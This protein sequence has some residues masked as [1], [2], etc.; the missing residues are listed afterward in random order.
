MQDIGIYKI[1]NLI[2]NKV[3]IGQSE[4]LPK[5]WKNHLNSYKRYLK[6]SKNRGHTILWKAFDKYGLN[7]FKFTVV[8][9]CPKEYLNKLE[10]K[11]ISIYDSY[12]KGY[13]ATIGGQ[14]GG[15]MPKKVYQFDLKGNFLKEWTSVSNIV[16]ILKFSAAGIYSNINDKTFSSNG[17]LWSYSKKNV[18]EKVIRYEE[19][20]KRVLKIKTDRKGKKCPNLWQPVYMFDKDGLFIKK[21][22]SRFHLIEYLKETSPNISLYIKR[23]FSAK[24]ELIF[25][26]DINF[27]KQLIKKL[28]DCYF[29]KMSF[30]PVYQVSFEGEVLNKFEKKSEATLKLNIDDS[31][32]SKAL[33]GDR[34]SAGG[35]LWVRD[36]KEIKARLEYF[37][38]RENRMVNNWNQSKLLTFKE[39]IEK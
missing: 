16:K 5:R 28:K 24:H 35:F 25:S 11:F 36:L 13:N 10:V 17:F 34:A 14:C 7:N 31:S 39:F 9:N 32:I 30:K 3:Y 20:L 19:S 6:G 37:K 1:E 18:K 27:D 4:N 33:K 12:N 26:N 22:P 8:A 2:N 15:T 23:G 29:S 38:Y 21:F